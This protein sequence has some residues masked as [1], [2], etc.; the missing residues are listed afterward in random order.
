MVS[1]ESRIKPIPLRELKNPSSPT[2]VPIPYP[3]TRAEIIIDLKYAIKVTTAQEG[4]D[5]VGKIPAYEQI[6]LN[7]LK[8]NPQ[9]KIGQIFKVKNRISGIAHE[10]TWFIL[11]RDLNDKNVVRVVLHANGLYFG[12][13]GIYPNREKDLVKTNREIL[14]ILTDA[15]KRTVDK[16]DIKSIDRVAFPSPLGDEFSPLWE[17]AMKDGDIYYYSLN[18]DCIYKGIEKKEWKNKETTS[19]YELAPNNEEF[20]PDEINDKILIL[21]KYDRKNPGKM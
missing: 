14:D 18:R 6:K 8:D 4:V 2:Y 21:K 19:Y 10:Y 3:K 1:A 7:L 17:I 16:N 20:L 9:Y 12:S 13:G 15:I 5:T 11:I